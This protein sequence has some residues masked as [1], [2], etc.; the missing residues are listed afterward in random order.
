MAGGEIAMGQNNWRLF[1][2]GGELA[3]SGF[4]TLGPTL[5]RSEGE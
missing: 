3:C 4:Y 5:N 2:Y 1:Q